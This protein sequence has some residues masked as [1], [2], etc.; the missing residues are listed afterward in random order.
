MCLKNTKD[1]YGIVAK[2]LHWLMALLIIGMIALGLYMEELQNSP[3]KF[4]L[5]GL[6]KSFGITLLF[7]VWLRVVW[8]VINV[9]PTLPD[10]LP[11]FEKGLARLGHLGLYAL[12]FA[13]PLTGWAMSS[14]AGFPVSVFGWFVMPNLLEA[15]HQMK[16]LFEDVHG[17]LAWV[18]M[19][20]IGLHV[21]AALLHHFYY[22]N[23][24]LR[25]MLPFYKGSDNVT[26]SDINTGC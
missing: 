8:R 7:L 2:G 1:S 9:T 20:V 16:E 10:S 6:H 13:L 18:L 15:N 14:A 26:N 12:M 5:F 21:L 4:R 19:A 22:K 23:D 25:K 11:A 24:V 3:D 17:L